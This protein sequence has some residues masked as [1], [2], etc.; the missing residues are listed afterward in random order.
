[1]KEERILLI[2]GGI[3]EIF[4]E[5]AEKLQTLSVTKCDKI[6]TVHNLVEQSVTEFG[7]IRPSIPSRRHW[8][9]LAG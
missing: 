4:A 1:M 7:H 2:A 8:D 3:E 5:E 9:P 6:R